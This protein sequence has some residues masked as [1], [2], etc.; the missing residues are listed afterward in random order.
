MLAFQEVLRGS[1]G[2]RGILRGFSGFRGSQVA[3]WGF[4]DFRGFQTGFRAFHMVPEF[5]AVFQG[6]LW[7]GPREVS[8]SLQRFLGAFQAIFRG[9]SVGL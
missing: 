5:S 7:Y 2:S 3:S 1:V 8:E 9:I 4:K 6:I